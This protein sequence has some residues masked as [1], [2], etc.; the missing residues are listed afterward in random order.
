MRCTP[1]CFYIM[2]FAVV[3]WKVPS[4]YTGDKAYYD[5]SWLIAEN[6]DQ[7]SLADAFRKFP[8]DADPVIHERSR[9]D[10][11]L[12]SVPEDHADTLDIVD[13][14]DDD[15]EEESDDEEADTDVEKSSNDMQEYEDEDDDDA[16]EEAAKAKDPNVSH[17]ED[18][19]KV[20][21]PA[22]CPPR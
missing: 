6:L 17:L 15:E 12:K 11:K 22:F 5:P 13:F 2:S 14:S 1:N 21:V 20:F 3:S 9:N 8:V 10:K 7:N 19:G 16:G 18:S 4:D